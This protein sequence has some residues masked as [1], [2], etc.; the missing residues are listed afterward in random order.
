MQSVPLWRQLRA[1]CVVVLT[2]CKL[3]RE[4]SVAVPRFALQ[5]VAQALC[6]VSCSQSSV[7]PPTEP[8]WAK[9]FLTW[10]AL[11]NTPEGTFPNSCWIYS[12][13]KCEFRLGVTAI[14]VLCK[15]LVHW[16]SSLFSFM[17]KTL[18]VSRIQSTCSLTYTSTYLTSDNISMC[19][20]QMLKPGL[21]T[22][23]CL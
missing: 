14:Q 3:L 8:Q 11:D 19:F 17:Q 9:T 20:P 15:V 10:S 21:K 18:H 12:I 13:Y 1:M 7:W 4:T 6:A 16:S 22:V 23:C 2:H 5:L